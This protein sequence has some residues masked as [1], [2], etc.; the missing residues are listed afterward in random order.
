MIDKGLNKTAKIILIIGSLLLIGMGITFL[1][2]NKNERELKRQFFSFNTNDN[3]LIKQG[4]PLM[5]SSAQIQD[6]QHYLLELG[7]IYNNE[8]ITDAIRLT[9]G[10][11]GI[12]GAGFNTALNEAIERGYLESFNDLYNRVS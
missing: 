5:N 9:G 7:V 8:I 4:S 2:M 12:R 3:P 10:A 1:I 6:M 11:D